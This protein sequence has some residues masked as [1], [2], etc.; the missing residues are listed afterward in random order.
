VTT[1]AR[2]GSRSIA[3]LALGV[4]SIVG[5]FILPTF[6]LKLGVLIGGMACVGRVMLPRLV[7]PERVGE[8]V[9]RPALVSG[10]LAV[11]LL[12]GEL[13]VRWAF[14]DVT[15]TMDNSS[16]FARRWREG[17]SE[18]SLGYRERE[19]AL[20]AEG[21]YRIALIGDSFA[22]GQGIEQSSRMS[23]R[24]EVLLNRTG[25]RF[26]VLNF[27][28]PGTHT[29]DHIEALRATVLP[30]QPDFVL[31]QWYFND[32]EGPD[33]VERPRPVPL[34]PSD[35]AAAWLH[36]RSGL[37]YLM[38]HAW[39]RLQSRLGTVDD[40][41]VHFDR[42]F[43]DP[44]SPSMVAGRAALAEFITTARQAG[45]GVGIVAFPDVELVQSPE[46]FALGYLIDRVMEVCHAHEV[47]CLDLREA[48]AG[49]SETE[50]W[51]ANKLD[52]HPGPLANE[53][54]ARAVLARF[55]EHWSTTAGDP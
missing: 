10:A 32:L 22:W 24:L 40:K 2:A 15:T 23:D 9:S 29:R 46:D 52:P 50:G 3:L 53:A 43:G 19:I 21:V 13:A 39:E 55:E 30:L 49:A 25:R 41:V 38:V 48:L 34:V 28:L 47:T 12:A 35:A 33:A 42:T 20:K 11:G 16:Y 17:V 5:V 45:V 18:N 26:E 37:Y 51:W 4:A 7:G 6:L 27:G 54:A 31:L 36:R 14:A 1:D 8:A 44:A